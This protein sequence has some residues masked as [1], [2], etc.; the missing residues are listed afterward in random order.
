MVS[1]S[2]WL[3]SSSYAQSLTS[4]FLITHKSIVSFRDTKHCFV[5]KDDGDGISPS[6]VDLDLMKG[7]LGSPQLVQS[8]T[9]QVETNSGSLVWIIPSGTSQSEDYFIR[10]SSPPYMSISAQ[11]KI[12]S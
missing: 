4:S 6:R 7:D 5:R 11:F 2:F 12:R 8:I 3:I 10:A 1:L 9:S